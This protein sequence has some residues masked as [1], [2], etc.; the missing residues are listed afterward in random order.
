VLIVQRSA[1]NAF[2]PNWC[3][4]GSGEVSPCWSNMDCIACEPHSAAR[5]ARAWSYRTL[6]GLAVVSVLVGQSDDPGQD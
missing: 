4:M 1:L 5:C 6:P 2:I 3:F